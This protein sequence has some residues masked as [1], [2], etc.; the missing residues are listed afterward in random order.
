M[1]ENDGQEGEPFQL[2]GRRYSEHLFI[3]LEF[4]R[5]QYGNRENDRKYPG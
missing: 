3:F 5:N 1:R 4:G 2:L